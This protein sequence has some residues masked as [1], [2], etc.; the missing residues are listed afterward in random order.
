[1][2]TIDHVGQ[3]AYPKPRLVLQPYR[4]H[5]LAI[6]RRDLFAFAQIGDGSGAAVLRDAKCDAAAGAAAVEAK[7]ETRLFRRSPMHEGIDAER[8]MFAD[9]PRRDAF[10]EFEAR[11]PDQRAIA[12]HP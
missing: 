5:H 7:H 9:Q 3:R 6:D 1:M 10:D 8:A 12:E 4:P 11:P 2:A